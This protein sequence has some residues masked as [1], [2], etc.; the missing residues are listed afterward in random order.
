[1]DRAA[2]EDL[3]RSRRERLTPAD[4]GLPPGSR[5]RTPGLRRDEVAGLAS[6]S[7]DYYT[8]LEQQ[9]GSHP[10][11]EVL[12]SLARALRF[13]DDERDHLFHLVGQAPPSRYAATA[14]LSPGLLHLLDRLTDCPAMVTDDL[15]VVLHQNAM[16]IAVT[17]DTSARRGR[18]RYSA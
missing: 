15:G 17:G 7:T 2:L 8:R 6:I 11:V 1:M 9:R 18:E 16:S 10:S 5:R 13:T 4:T 12:A 3:L 14:H